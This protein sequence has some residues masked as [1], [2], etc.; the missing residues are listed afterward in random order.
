MILF[1]VLVIIALGGFVFWKK[2]GSSKEKADL[3]QYYGIQNND[4]LAVVVDDQI[5]G[6]R[7][8]GTQESSSAGGKFYDGIPYVEYSVVRN[9]INERFYWDS[10]ENILL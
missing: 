10:N 6:A 7:D 3:K 1:V 8:A 9:Y 5:M 4:D 2:Y